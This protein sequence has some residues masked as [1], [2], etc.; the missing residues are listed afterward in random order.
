VTVAAERNGGAV[1]VSVA[2]RGPGFDPA[3]LPQ[4]FE[5]F[6][7]SADSRGSGLGLAIA[8]RLVEAHGGTIRAEQAA[9]GGAVIRFELPIQPA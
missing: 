3:V 5:R 7:K 9:G 6:A 1:T 2:D 8:R 4:L